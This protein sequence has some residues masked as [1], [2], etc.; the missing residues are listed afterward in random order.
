MCCIFGRT[1]TKWMVAYLKAF[2]AY[3]KAYKFLKF[4]DWQSMKSMTVSSMECVGALTWS[5]WVPHDGIWT[6]NWLIAL[7]TDPCVSKMMIAYLASFLGVSPFQHTQD[8][9]V[10]AR[11]D[12]LYRDSMEKLDEVDDQAC[13]KYVAR[14]ILAWYTKYPPKNDEAASAVEA[15]APPPRTPD[16]PAAAVNEPHPKLGMALQM[17]R[18][19]QPRLGNC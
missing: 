15:S 7:P 19:K 8:P 13:I 2:V 17:M 5:T 14:K 16:R 1:T 3:L 18:A 10:D 6:G 12:L 11:L 4:S 9:M